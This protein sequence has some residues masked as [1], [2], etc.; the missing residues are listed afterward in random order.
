MEGAGKDLAASINEMAQSHAESGKYSQKNID[1]AKKQ[2]KI[3][4]A[5]INVIKAQ[6]KGDKLGIIAA[7]AKLKMSTIGTKN[8]DKQT[9]QLI[10]QYKTQQKQQQSSK[11][12]NKITSKRVDMMGAM[13]KAG[14]ALSEG[15]GE[16]GSMMGS[17]ITNPLTFI[18]SLMKMFD[19]FT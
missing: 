10:Q 1:L 19:G 6:Q 13:G 12:L 9:K 17:A 3:G 16:A 2:S 15:V 11:L 7:K 4:S 18:I 8:G 14:A 5:M